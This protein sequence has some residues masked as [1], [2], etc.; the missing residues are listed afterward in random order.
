M[1]PCAR[2]SAQIKCCLVREPLRKLNAAYHSVAQQQPHENSSGSPQ[3][4][5]VT[6]PTP[7]TAS[8]SNISLATERF[9]FTPLFRRQSLCHSAQRSAMHRQRQLPLTWSGSIPWIWPRSSCGRAWPPAGTASCPPRVGEKRRHPRGLSIPK[10]R[11]KRRP[12]PEE[13][14]GKP[15]KTEK[16]PK[17]KTKSQRKTFHTKNRPE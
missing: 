17:K 1:L 16:T 2:T 11:L 12:T 5:G 14:K 13:T 4:P 3:T 15:K 6:R 10:A 8:C 7:Q 9:S